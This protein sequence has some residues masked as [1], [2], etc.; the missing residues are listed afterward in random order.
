[1]RANKILV[2]GAIAILLVAG[3]AAQQ[4]RIGPKD[5]LVILDAKLDPS[6]SSTTLNR[7]FFL[8]FG[9]ELDYTEGALLLE[10]NFLGEMH[11]KH[12]EIEIIGSQ[13]ALQLIRQQKL[14]DEYRAFAG[15]YVN[16]GVPTTAFLQTIGR[17]GQ[18]DGILIG[19]IV[20]FG[21]NRQRRFLNTGL[22][23][24]S[25]NRDR[26]VV[27]MEIRLLRAKDGREIW[28]GVHAIEG[29]KNENVRDI[30]KTV[31]QVFGA[32]FGRLPY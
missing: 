11:Q 21:V 15:N 6:F 5:R 10:Q 27:G 16:T 17:V 28:W 7:L 30:S 4:R 20:G 19:Q 2:T 23:I 14:A 24:I 8:P 26:A 22:G 1:M 9:N 3:V 25:W 29:E 12:P 32:Y 13:D 31:G 18:V